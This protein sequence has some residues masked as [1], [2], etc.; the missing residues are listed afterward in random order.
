MTEGVTTGAETGEVTDEVTD[1]PT[2][3]EEEIGEVNGEVTDEEALF[4]IH[5]DF[6]VSAT[7]RGV[8]IL[9]KIF[10]NIING[11]IV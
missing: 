7:L 3:E 9:F 5:I 4:T 6:L 2:G 10:Y 8:E 11:V 1:E